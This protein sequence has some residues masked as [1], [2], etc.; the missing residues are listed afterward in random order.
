MIQEQNAQLYHIA[1]NLSHFLDHIL[2]LGKC[3]VQEKA[4][5][6]PLINMIFVWQIWRFLK[7]LATAK[8]D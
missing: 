8:D 7:V 4:Q 1:L 2:L 5:H 6:S 3:P